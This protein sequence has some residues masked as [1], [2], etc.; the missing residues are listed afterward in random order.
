[1]RQFETSSPPLQDRPWPYVPMFEKPPAG[2]THFLGLSVVE[3]RRMLD[4]L[5]HTPENL[6]QLVNGFLGFLYGYRFGYADSPCFLQT[7]D[8][9]EISLEQA[10]IVLER[11]LV[12]FLG[13]PAVPCVHS[14]EELVAAL[15]SLVADN[16]GIDHPLFRFLEEQASYD[17]VR[18]FLLNDVIRNE[19]VDDEVALLVAGQ[20]GVMKEAA[21]VNLFD[22][23]GRGKQQHFH[24]YWL[25]ILLESLEAWDALLAYRSNSPLKNG[26][27]VRPKAKN[28]LNDAQCK[29]SVPLVQQTA[30]ARPWFAGLT[31]NVFAMLLTRPGYKRAAYGHF[32]I[33]ESWVPQHFAPIL[34]GMDRVGLR[35]DDN[36]IY[37]TAHITLDPTHTDELILGLTHQVPKLTPVECTQILWGCQLA[38]RGA[39]AQYDRMLAYL[40]DLS[41]APESFSTR[42]L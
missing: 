10:K 19:I 30:E 7:D 38:I 21:A 17:A 40:R 32:I 22:E 12:E 3:Q 29:V 24:T 8:D 5:R 33:T 13:V 18:L 23:C 9:L 35:R 28:Q 42:I 11:E 20:Q 16:P 39:V 27:R 41:S 6:A 4:T 14:Q 15:Q 34:Q 26:D 37:F 1:M 25:R 36:D 31:S 2:L